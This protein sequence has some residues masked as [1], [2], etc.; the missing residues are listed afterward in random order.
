[1]NF[2]R[3]WLPSVIPGIGAFLNPTVLMIIAGLMLTSYVAGCMHEKERF[4]EFKG[5]VEALGKQAHEAAVKRNAELNLA[6]KE[7]DNAYKKR[8]RDRDRAHA[9]ELTRVRL[10][11]RG[12]VLPGNSEGAG[13][14]L[15]T[16]IC[17]DRKK[18]ESGLAGS[19]QRFLERTTVLIQSG[20]DSL[21]DSSSARAWAKQVGVCK[22]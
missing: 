11:S 3:T 13:Q 8:L 7:A 17:F 9:D 12:S 10:D 4:D 14:P 19:I 16:E 15:S 6:K 21:E 1:M 2:I 18:L 5:G 20:G 22:D